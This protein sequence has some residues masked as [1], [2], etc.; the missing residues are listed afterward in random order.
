MERGGGMVNNLNEAEKEEN[1][2]V[3][4]RE[5]KMVR[6]TSPRWKGQQLGAKERKERKK[7]R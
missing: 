2:R 7:G 4:T 5:S 1:K 6:A 3:M